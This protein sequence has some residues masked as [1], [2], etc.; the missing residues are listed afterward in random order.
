[1]YNT[2]KSRW[3]DY[4]HCNKPKNPEDEMIIKANIN[5]S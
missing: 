3:Y 5:F 4:S 2:F 1:M